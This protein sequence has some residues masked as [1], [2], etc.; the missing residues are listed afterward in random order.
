VLGMAA[1]IELI[2]VIDVQIYCALPTAPA[3]PFPAQNDAEQ[4]QPT[5]LQLG[6]QLGGMAE[7]PG[8]RPTDTNAAQDEDA[9]TDDPAA[10]AAT[11]CA[12]PAAPHPQP[13]P[14]PMPTSFPVTPSRPAPLLSEAVNSPALVANGRAMRTVELVPHGPPMGSL[15]SSPRDVPRTLSGTV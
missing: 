3:E 2:K 10:V 15:S 12:P 7:Q 8:R 13:V 11:H 6:Q 1:L 5:G 9:T 4:A 14:E